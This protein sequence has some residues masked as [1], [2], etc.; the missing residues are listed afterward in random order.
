M[1][2]AHRSAGAGLLGPELSRAVWNVPGTFSVHQPEFP[3]RRTG[4]DV[5]EPELRAVEAALVAR[6][7]I[8]RP[9]T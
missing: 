8:Q 5:G 1:V 6:L 4:V 2:A 3:L 9:E 7:R